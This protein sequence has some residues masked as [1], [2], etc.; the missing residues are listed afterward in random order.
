MSDNVRVYEIAEEAGATSAEVIAKSR[1]LGIELKSPQSS[2]SF[3][4]AEEIANYIMTGKS[5][6]AYFIEKKKREQIK[7]HQEK[8][9][10]LAKEEKKKVDSKNKQQSVHST[11]MS[12]L[13]IVR[14]KWDN[15]HIN[16]TDSS[17]NIPENKKSRGKE[18]SYVS[19]KLLNNEVSKLAN[20]PTRF[21]EKKAVDIE[22]DTFNKT[23]NDKKNKTKE[24]NSVQA[25]SSNEEIAKLVHSGKPIKHEGK[26]VIYA[27][28]ESLALNSYPKVIIEINNLK[29]IKYLKWNLQSESGV[30]AIIGENG[31]GKSSLLISIA[32]LVNPPIFQSEFTGSGHYEKS[33]ISY[34][35]DK[36]SFTWIKNSTTQNSWRQGPSDKYNM[37]KLKGFF[38]SSI[39]SGTRFK[40]VDN[41]VKDGLDYRLEDKV[42]KASSFII[43]AMNYILFGNKKTHYKF[44]ELY[45]IQ[46]KRKRKKNPAQKHL[47][48][49]LYK[50]Y[51][52][53]LSDTEYIKEHLFSTGEYFLLKLLKF[54][55]TY[56]DN[57]SVIPA[58]I[59]IDE[60][61][62]SLHPLAQ[63]RLIEHINKLVNEMN[64]IIIFASHSLQILE[65]IPPENT[66][67]VEKNVINEHTV[68]NPIGKGYIS[69]KMHK[70]ILNDK[71]I[72]V[73][74]DMAKLYMEH[75]LKDAEFTKHFSW[76][77]IKIGGCND[78][79]RA[80]KE[81]STF[82]PMYGSADVMVAVDDDAKDKIKGP[83]KQYIFWYHHIPIKEDIEKYIL[84]LISYED[85]DFVSFIGSIMPQ[86]NFY[87]LT[88]SLHSP[89]SC[90]NDLVTELAK[91]KL[92]NY[93]GKT[94]ATKI[95]MKELIVE[96]IYKKNIINDEHKSFV[97]E[98]KRFFDGE[99]N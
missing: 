63:T 34:T 53:K 4:D 40:N 31:S 10:I 20:K 78:V 43:E 58:L 33:E 12:G 66:Y 91:L 65:H 81:N 32:K 59:I 82:N 30:Y 90:F 11:K 92:H 61:E 38:E 87:D 16:A 83:D 15:P 14:K 46:A 44:N 5:N 80:A 60:I 85:I 86:G 98:I 24:K 57:E 47:K 74:D 69:S 42:T 55:D 1:D 27:E 22:V 9:N 71:V 88:V 99:R 51:A 36:N 8:L 26:E 45:S 13:K 37:P 48:T 89:K 68:I 95:R 23:I 75:T 41:Y 93:D 56:T 67:F 77:V 39:L 72:L 96:Y 28:R 35:I 50:Y 18:N 62:L 64:L 97:N 52:L 3:E 21:D 29:T 94:E 54:L 25:K 6:K 2:V 49:E 7:R 17:K 79:I 73:E 70:H 84:S 19:E 76:K